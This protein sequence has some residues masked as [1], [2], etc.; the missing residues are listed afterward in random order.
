MKIAFFVL[1]AGMGGH[2]RS[3]ATIAEALANQG[4]KILFIGP[5]DSP[6]LQILHD[7]K[8]CK[9]YGL[10][11][12]CRNLICD[13]LLV[14]KT[15]KILREQEVEIIHTFDQH[16]HAIGYFL[17]KILN[18]P[19]LSTICGGRI[20]TINSLPHTRPIIVF[21]QELK[22]QLIKMG[23][24]IKDIIV[25]AARID[26]KN[27]PL[28]ITRKHLLQT[29]RIESNKK[30]IL[31]VTRIAWGKEQGIYS[32]LKSIDYLARRRK[33]FVFLL[34]GNIESS[35][36]KR[37][38][39]KKIK[40]INRNHGRM[41][42]VLDDK[43]FISNPLSTFD[44][45]DIILGIG[46]VS[47]EGMMAR[48]PVLIVG[49]K[50]F[51]GIISSKNIKE[52]SHYNFSGRNIKNEEIRVTDIKMCL[53]LDSLLSDDKLRKEYA[54]FGNVWAKKHLDVKTAAQ[55]Y[56]DTYRHLLTQEQQK[57]HHL[58]H[59]FLKYLFFIFAPIKHYSKIALK[60][61]FTTHSK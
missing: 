21:S 34:I 22:E 10:S 30:I 13:P 52:L 45:A 18:I 39:L 8:K 25:E 58:A 28:R 35:T 54:S 5:K 7:K 37:K 27:F 12:N 20:K 19:I 48:K 57:G 40:Q 31:M 4:H 61:L 36:I 60:H 59:L 49:N 47:F 15:S 56:N 26:T 42:V 38:I 16:S 6:V 55:T 1:A 32:S 23:V 9:I 41:V 11:N 51:A 46:R 44:L 43:K 3:A 2:A 33:D 29:L 14:K 50:G 17:S 53:L 24:K